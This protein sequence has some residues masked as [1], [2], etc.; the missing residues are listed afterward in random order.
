MGGRGWR[1]P[2]KAGREMVRWGGCFLPFPTGQRYAQ[3]WVTR[4]DVCLCVG[5]MV[6]F[7]TFLAASDGDNFNWLKTGRKECSDCHNLHM[8]K[9]SLLWG[10][11]DPGIPAQ[12]GLLFSSPPF[13][14]VSPLQRVGTQR[15]VA[16]G[17]LTFA[18]NPIASSWE[19]SRR[20]L[21]HRAHICS[22]VDQS[23]WLGCQH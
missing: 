17:S 7:R 13:F 18:C 16:M 20:A 12:S 6:L 15:W 11:W 8:H 14:V 3:P 22:S 4:R 5:M 1:K 19:A 10:C 21:L 2:Q 9:W 23:S